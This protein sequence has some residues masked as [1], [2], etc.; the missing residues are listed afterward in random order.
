MIFLQNLDLA[1]RKD[2]LISLIE[3]RSRN[4]YPLLNVVIHCN[5]LSHAASWSLEVRS[6]V[7]SGDLGEA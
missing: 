1:F 3:S 5:P 4:I 7:S 2:F 6:R